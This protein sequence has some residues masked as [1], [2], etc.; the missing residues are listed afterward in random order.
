MSIF[1]KT[2]HD[3]RTFNWH[4]WLTTSSEF[5]FSQKNEKTQSEVVMF[6]KANCFWLVFLNKTVFKITQDGQRAG[7]HDFLGKVRRN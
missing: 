5:I 4:V 3:L 1:T 6:L 7:A 2:V